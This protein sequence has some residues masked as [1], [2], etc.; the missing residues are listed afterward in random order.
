MNP[1][2]CTV[3]HKYVIKSPWSKNV[4]KDVKKEDDRTDDRMINNKKPGNR[5]DESRINE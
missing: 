3:W 1:F 2:K 4:K 5:M